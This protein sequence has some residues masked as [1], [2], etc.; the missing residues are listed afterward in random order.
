MDTDA[1]LKMLKDA[2][3][4]LNEARIRVA[5][6]EQIVDGL[7]GLLTAAGV[8]VGVRRTVQEPLPGMASPRDAVSGMRPRDA[9]KYVLTRRPGLPMTARRVY[10]YLLEH[11]LANPGVKSGVAAYDMA[12]RRLAEEPG[13]GVERDE[14][15]GTYTL[16]AGVNAPKTGHYYVSIDGKRLTLDDNEVESL[17]GRRIRNAEAHGG[18]YVRDRSNKLSAAEA[19]DLEE[20]QK[21]RRLTEAE[22]REY[23]AQR[24]ALLKRSRDMDFVTKHGNPSS[25]KPGDPV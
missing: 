25:K 15:A 4:D 6:L 11:G 18:R 20:R 16:R 8:D 3:R 10:D 22:Q 23:E 19:R 7:T 21:P 24:A 1:Q 9:V 2:R 14:D 13:S 5:H 12:L 17:E